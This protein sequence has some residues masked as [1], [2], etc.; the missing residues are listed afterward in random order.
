MARLVD[1]FGRRLHYLR[2]SVTDRC[3]LRCGYC[4]PQEGIAKLP[5]A[6]ILSLEELGRAARVAVG[7]GVDKIRLTGGEPLVRRDLPVLMRSLAALNPAPDLRLTT[8]GILLAEALDRLMAVGLRAVN[9]SLDTLRPER[10]GAIT[11]LSPEAGRQAFA[12][13]W[14]GIETALARPG[15]K[16]KLN[17]VLLAGVNQDELADFAALT[18]ERRLA[19]RFI[20]YMPVGRGKRFDRERFLAADQALAAAAGLGE[21]IE[22]PRRASDGPARRLAIA[23]AAGELGVIHALSSH[24]C[25]TCNRLRLSAEGR[26]MPCLFSETG[27]DLKALLRSGAD[28]EALA[29]AFL[30]AAAQKPQRHHQSSR[31]QGP[32]GCA[33]SRLGG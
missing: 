5:H 9:I 32:G 11:G 18:L 33:M 25:A 31:S 30:T 14:R 16:V 4:M 12:G 24:F 6:E 19:V 15:L 17:V 23:G 22:L 21:L 2:L 26:L 10:Y 1:P 20:E 3:N 8:N 28:D 7:L 29:Q 27:V 13:V